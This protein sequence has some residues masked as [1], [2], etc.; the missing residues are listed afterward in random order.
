MHRNK[1]NSKK[2]NIFYIKTIGQFLYK[3]NTNLK[4]IFHTKVKMYSSFSLLTLMSFPTCMTDF[5]CGIQNK[6]FQ[7]VFQLFLS[8]Q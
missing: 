5:F 3:K 6:T 1:L 8:K 7:T 4:Y 2:L